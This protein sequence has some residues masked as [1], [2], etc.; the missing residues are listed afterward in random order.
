MKTN[1][2]MVANLNKLAN[3]INRKTREIENLHKRQKIASQGNMRFVNG[4]VNKNNYTNENYI[5]NIHNAMRILYNERKPLMNKYNKTAKKYR[6]MLKL[7][8]AGAP[9]YVRGPHYNYGWQKKNYVTFLRTKRTTSGNLPYNNK[10]KL[11]SKYQRFGAQSGSGGG[12][13]TAYVLLGG[14]YNKFHP[15]TQ[16]VNAIKKRIASEIIREALYRPPKKN[17]SPGGLGPKGGRLY[18]KLVKNWKAA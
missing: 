9:G 2:E 11:Y 17:E 16:L 5:R 18:A 3:E 1:R 4:R 15:N 10:N 14:Y 6:E 12:G 7:P 13:G 8:A